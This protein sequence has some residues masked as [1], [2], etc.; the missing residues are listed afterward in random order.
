MRVVLIL[1]LAATA[2]A[3][4]ISL[5]VAGLRLMP[6]RWNKAA[7][8][9][10][11]DRYARLAASQ[12]AQLAIAPEGFLEGYVANVKANP[13]V[14]REQY[15]AVAENIDGPSLIRVRSLAR[16][17]K[18]YLGL[19]F[20]ERRDERLYNSMAVFS[21]EGEV[22]LHYS[23]AHNDD[24]EPYNTL[25]TAFNVA[26]TPLGRWGALICYDRQLPETARMLAVKGA[27]LILVPAWGGHGDMND[28]MM[29]TR[30]FEN[31]VWV[32][33]VHPQRV[34]IIDPR[35][36]IVAKDQGEAD[37]IVH[38]RITLDGRIGK[39]AIRSRRPE[40]YK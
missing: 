32:M 10:K 24:D 25:G 15:A 17:L 30:A 35:G 37:Q 28:A 21:P 11:F 36:N 6:E 16:E 1:L 33:F 40:V 9:T 3:G 31:S 2:W 18:I 8:L 22:A 23:K 7:N 39:G 12:G 5:S 26:R 34:L 14:T 38:A 20:A 27:Q 29:R 19:G 4:D 13:G